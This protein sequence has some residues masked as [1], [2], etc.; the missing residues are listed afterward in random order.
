MKFFSIIIILFFTF[1]GTNGLSA[2]EPATIKV[3]KESN[4]S[5]AE[6]DNTERKLMVVDR[7]GNLK[8]N[9]IASYKLYVKTKRET[10]EFEGYGNSLSA[11]M[12]KYLNKQSSATK[13]FFTEISAVDDDGHLVKLPDV[14][15]T[16][17]P[18]CSN[19]GKGDKRR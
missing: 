5:K 19:C 9:K 1:C 3:R 13:I 16:W 10:K 15:N 12:I 14:I 2:Q 8:E 17:F 7:F 4:L 6:F 18:D 11:E